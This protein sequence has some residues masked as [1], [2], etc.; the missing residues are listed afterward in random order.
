MANHPP[1]LAE[2]VEEAADI[3]LLYRSHYGLQYALASRYTLRNF[4]GAVYPY[5]EATIG[6]TRYRLRQLSDGP[7]RRLLVPV[8]V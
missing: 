1:S 2:I 8:L 6:L 5:R 3:D 4:Q 7:F